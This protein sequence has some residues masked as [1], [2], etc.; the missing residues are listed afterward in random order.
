[1]PP[2]RTL[3]GMREFTRLIKLQT[4][5]NYFDKQRELSQRRE[6]LRVTTAKSAVENLLAEARTQ[7]AVS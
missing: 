6:R 7:Q 4:H 2:L 1:M 3:S 5:P